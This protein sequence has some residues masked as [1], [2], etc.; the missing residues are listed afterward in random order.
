LAYRNQQ[1]EFKMRAVTLTIIAYILA[2]STYP[3][4]AQPIF[5][6]WRIEYI[7][8]ERVLNELMTTFRFEADGQLNTTIG[9]NTIMG[10]LESEDSKLKVGSIA[11]TR[12]A[13]IKPLRE[14]EEIYI[15]ALNA[16]R[17]YRVRADTLTLLDARGHN[18]VVLRRIG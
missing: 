11:T 18:L 8:H 15:T 14:Q 5:G 7:Q 2:S 9:C 1:V 4:G 3:V 12:M 13:C 17:S 6:Q 16:V 10:K